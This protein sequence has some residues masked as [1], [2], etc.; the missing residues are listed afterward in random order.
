M[1]NFFT[2]KSIF[3]LSLFACIT[4]FLFNLS[5][6]HD[7][8]DD[9]A[10]Y[11]MQAKAVS[12]KNIDFYI[13][14]KSF[15][16]NN[17][18]VGLDSGHLAN[19]WAY[20]FYLS[21]FYKFFGLNLFI[22]KI[23]SF[24][25]FVFF[26]I[27]LF[28]GYKN[29]LNKNWIL[30]LI[31][32][33]LTNPWII[34]FSNFIGPDFFFLFFNTIM[35]ILLRL[36]LIEKKFFINLY[37][38]NFFL[39][40]LI[41][42]CFL[43]RG[44]GVVLIILL[45]LCQVTN[46][47]LDHIIFYSQKFINFYF[48]KKIFIKNLFFKRV[49]YKNNPTTNIQL[50]TTVNNVN[51]F[52]SNKLLIFLIPYLVFIFL[53]LTPN[54]FLPDSNTRYLDY[55]FAESPS[56]VLYNIFYYIKLPGIFFSYEFYFFSIPFFIVGAIKKF[57]IIYIE[58]LFFLLY[59]SVLV[60]F[61]INQGVR[62]ILPLIPCYLIICFLGF[63]SSIILF[64]GYTNL[65]LAIKFLKFLLL[66]FIFSML[67]LNIKNVIK[68]NKNDPL[69]N[70]GPYEFEAQEMF[71]FIKEF[72]KNND[73]EVIFRK[74]TAMMLLTGHL[75]YAVTD[76]KDLKSEKKKLLV[77]DKVNL[78]R[79]ISLSEIQEKKNKKEILEVFNNTKFI[80]YFFK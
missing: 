19:P 38:H 67:I 3:F 22:F 15:L 69:L 80:I 53:K 65:K 35:I 47:Y 55:I 56:Y 61:P 34:E 16:M 23:A 29:L 27:A 46:C 59:L 18:S 13:F 41:Y 30:L 50:L 51:N 12:E 36:L 28:I 73:E 44:N 40:C 54:Y 43:V 72:S 52:I 63:K 75:S 14:S 31:L 7:W 1:K 77:I 68:R 4:L 32:I 78:D 66:V 62:Y 25:P 6:G 71:R 10:V 70:N 58:L 79:Q 60:V 11:I 9:F 8:G 21:F 26:I 42:F 48:N 49:F 74:P 20:P 2:K 5:S 37:I 24:L 57:R 33:F 76:I 45:F 17:S 39:G 64:S